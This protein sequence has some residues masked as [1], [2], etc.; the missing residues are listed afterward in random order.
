MKIEMPRRTSIT[1]NPL[2]YYQEIIE[3]YKKLSLKYERKLIAFAKKGNSLA[4]NKLLLHL[5]GFFLFRIKTTLYPSIVKQYGED[6]LQECLLLAIE[7]IHT[8]NLRY[9]NKTGELQPVHLSTYMW[10]S[11]TGLML[12]FIKTNKEICF[13]NLSSWDIQKYE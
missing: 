2:E 3:Q 13:S 12:S 6:I 5:V 4:Q 8:Y 11:V 9:K 10:K 7:K 1:V